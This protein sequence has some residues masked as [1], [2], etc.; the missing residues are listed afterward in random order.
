MSRASR[1]PPECPN[2]S[3]EYLLTLGH[4]VAIKGL[5]AI[6]RKS[7]R[8]RRMWVLTSNECIRLTGLTMAHRSTPNWPAYLPAWGLRPQE[9]KSI[10]QSTYC[11]SRGVD[12]IFLPKF[13]CELN[14]IEQCRGY[15][16]WIYQHYPTS[17]KEADLERNLL[18]SL[19]AVPLQSMRK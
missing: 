9:T 3:W 6:R 2:R 11:R 16:K 17:S 7:R 18:A 8:I 1:D 19:E 14:F 12:I 13:Y 5:G 4:I 15:A 10:K